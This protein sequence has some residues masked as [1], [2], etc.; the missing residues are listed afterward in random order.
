MSFLLRVAHDRSRAEG[1]HEAFGKDSTPSLDAILL[2]Q[3]TQ[4][5]GQIL[6][7]E[8]VKPAA[9]N[10]PQHVIP[11]FAFTRVMGHMVPETVH[12]GPNF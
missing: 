11:N 6:K 7:V 1:D 4:L 12:T 8:E 9:A 10:V 5:A 3:V 2:R